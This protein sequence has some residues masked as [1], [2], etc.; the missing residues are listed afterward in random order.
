[1]IYVYAFCPR[2]PQEFTLPAGIASPAVELIAV[3]DIGAFA[4][5]DLDVSQFKD[6][7]EKLIAAVL[8]HDRILG[9]LFSQTPLLPLRFGTQFTHKTSLETYL[10]THQAAHLQRLT[11]LAGRAEYL[12]KLSPKPPEPSPSEETLKG[13]A[14][15]LA[16]KARLQAQA[17]AEALQAEELQRFLA[18]L[19]AA[20]VQFIQGEP[21]E[22]EER[23]HLLSNRAPAA[24]QAEIFYWQQQLPSWQI[25]CSGPLPPYH[26]VG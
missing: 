14:Y 22:S 12:V 9:E 23:L 5:V 20:G 21:A 6:D 15:F 2:P 19:T 1:M 26:F 11:D 25:D 4:E 17:Q 10:Q 3:E 24:A 7:D 18:Q 13:R 16:K 8:A